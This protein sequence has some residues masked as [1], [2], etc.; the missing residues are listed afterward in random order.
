MKMQRNKLMFGF[1]GLAV[2]GVASY[3][4]YK[5]RERFTSAYTS[6]R[7][8]RHMDVVAPQIAERSHE[9]FDRGAT[10]AEHLTVKQGAQ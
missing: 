3:F 2:V 4:G 10:L 8:R 7:T 9:R 6:W 1:L 5:N